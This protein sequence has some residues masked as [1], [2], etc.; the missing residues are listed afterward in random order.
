MSV[1]KLIAA[2][3]ALLALTLAGCA[4]TPAAQPTQTKAADTNRAACATYGAQT[5][6]AGD[7]IVYGSDPIG[8][9]AWQDGLDALADGFDK[10]AVQAHGQIAERMNDTVTNLPDPINKIMSD[11]TTYIADVKRVRNAC[12]AGGFSTASFVELQHGA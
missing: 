11:P 6:V 8:Q 5:K 4:T 1:K 2:S 12:D 7:L 10:A 3:A 9:A